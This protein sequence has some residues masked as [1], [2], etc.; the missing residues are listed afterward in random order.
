MKICFECGNIATENHHIVPKSLG[1]TKTVPLCSTCHMK[2]HDLHMTRRV[3]NSPELT[4]RGIDK[5]RAWD[6]FAVYQAIYIFEAESVDEIMKV[7]KRE[8]QSDY[9]KII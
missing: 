4:K 2:V 5:I 6:L 3:D 7:M 1:G 9:K 8:F